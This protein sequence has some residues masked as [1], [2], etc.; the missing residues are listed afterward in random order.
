MRDAAVETGVGLRRGRVGVARGDGDPPRDQHVDEV[1]RARQLRRERHVRH[2][3]AREQPVQQRRV[4]VAAPLGRMGAE[5]AGGEERALQVRAEDLRPVRQRAQRGQDV[6]LGRGDERRQVR[7]D[8]GREQR[9]ARARVTLAVGVHEVDAGEAVDLE[10]DEAGRGD[11]PA[12]PAEADAGD[13]IAV[14]LDVARDERA[15]DQRRR[16]PEP[17]RRA[18]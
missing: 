16:D 12:G 6:R 1:E 8:A 3:A 13:A 15:V 18:R 10:I 14:D 5:P 2:A 9:R 17:H 4:G 11:P 7:G